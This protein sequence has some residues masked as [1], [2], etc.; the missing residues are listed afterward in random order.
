[1]LFKKFNQSNYL[2]ES[3]LMSIRACVKLIYTSGKRGK[4]EHNHLKILIDLK[5]VNKVLKHANLRAKRDKSCCLFRVKLLL[6]W[7]G[8]KKYFWNMIFAAIPSNVCA[9]GTNWTLSRS[10]WFSFV[11]LTHETLNQTDPCRHRARP[12]YGCDH[13]TDL[14]DFH[15]CSICPGHTQGI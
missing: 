2:D 13:D 15:L 1:M 5:G 10:E 12:I 8:G 9:F 3:K 11:S 4:N 14:S 7:N 6:N